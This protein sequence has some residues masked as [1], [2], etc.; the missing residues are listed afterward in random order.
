MNRTTVALLAALE[1]VIVAAVGLGIALVPLTILWAAQYHLAVD[2]FIFWRAAGDIWLVGHGVNLTVALDPVTAAT[3]G[4]PGAAV[5]FQITIAALGF[6]LFTAVFGVRTGLRA[7]ETAYRATGVVTA[8]AVFAALS[9][10]VTF[11]CGSTVVRPSLWQGILL[12]PFVY[13]IG[14]AIGIGAGL[15]RRER[16]RRV[17]ATETAPVARPGRLASAFRM[18]L[19]GLPPALRSGAAAAARGGTAAA[20]LVVVGAA[21][22]LT[23]LIVVDFG[24]IVGLYERLQSGA[25]GGAA[26]TIAQ[27]AFIP[28]LV[29]WTAAWLIG[30]GFAI[31]TGSSVGPVATQL[32]PIPSVPLFGVLPSGSLAFGFLG[33]LVPLLAGFIA[34]V[35]LRSHVNR[36]AAVHGPGW[37]VLTAVGVGCVA[38]IELGLLAWWSGGALGPGRLHEVG[39]NPWMV[40]LLAAAEVAVAAGIGMLAGGRIRR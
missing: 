13:A 40:G 10:I 24:A 36:S 2:W 31:G 8:L 15:V 34:A 16:M 17:A 9:A 1:A 28:N 19:D 14:I 12:P 4:L 25:L 18:R 35:L 11:T 32:G 3:L 7:S 30:P 37:V 26:L 21:L 6:A 22:V 20:A 27:A 33:L 5:P 38:G 23:V 39:P 29:I